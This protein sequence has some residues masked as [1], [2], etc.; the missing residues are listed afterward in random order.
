MD[1][2]KSPTLYLDST[3]KRYPYSIPAGSTLDDLVQACGAK[4]RD[5]GLLLDQPVESPASGSLIRV[6]MIAEEAT[7]KEIRNGLQ[8]MGLQPASL[9][10]ALAL[11]ARPRNRW[12]TG[13]PVLCFGGHPRLTKNLLCLDDED[14]NIVIRGEAPEADGVFLLHCMLF[15]KPLS[16]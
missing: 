9:A 3:I 15:A 12:M 11:C 4:A 16:E 5:S 8:S 6:E 13:K 14:G 10:E 7:E 1:S 2:Y